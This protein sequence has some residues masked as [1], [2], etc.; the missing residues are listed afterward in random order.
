MILGLRES[1]R[2]LI[3]DT[4]EIPRFIGQVGFRGRAGEEKGTTRE[5]WKPQLAESLDSSIMTPKSGL[6]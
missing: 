4:G 5:D 6:L 1:E 2:D 3:L